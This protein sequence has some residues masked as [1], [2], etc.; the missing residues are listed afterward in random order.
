MRVLGATAIED[1]LQDG[2]PETIADLKEAGIKVRRQATKDGN[3][4]NR[5]RLAN[6][7][8]SGH[9]YDFLKLRCCFVVHKYLFVCVRC[10]ILRGEIFVFWARACACLLSGVGL[11]G[12]Q[13]DDCHQHWVFLPVADEQNGADYPGQRRTRRRP[14]ACGSSLESLLRQ[15]WAFFTV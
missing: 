14:G 1:R 6:E 9:E 4:V 11:N 10:K 5:R 15:V 12:R 2:V 8:I 13:N 3:C 7:R